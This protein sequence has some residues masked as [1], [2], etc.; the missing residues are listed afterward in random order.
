MTIYLLG[1][2]FVNNILLVDCSGRPIKLSN[3]LNSYNKLSQ[4][5][6]SSF[7]FS[8]FRANSLA[9]L[10]HMESKYDRQGQSYYEQI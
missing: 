10:S 8:E 5:S 2:L 4:P 3:P 1:E 6:Y 9:A 7:P